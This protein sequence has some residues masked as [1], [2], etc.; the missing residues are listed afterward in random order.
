MKDQACDDQE[1]KKDGDASFE[2]GDYI[3]P[4]ESSQDE[5]ECVQE[6]EAPENQCMLILGCVCSPTVL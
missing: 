1:L 6:E 2:K 3:Y 5:E 4:P